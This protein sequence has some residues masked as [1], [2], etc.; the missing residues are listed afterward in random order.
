MIISSSVKS[1]YPITIPL[2]VNSFKPVGN[3]SFPIIPLI[4]VVFPAFVGPIKGIK[5]TLYISKKS[6]NCFIF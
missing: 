5:I 1:A 2:F 3:K 4:I 6:I